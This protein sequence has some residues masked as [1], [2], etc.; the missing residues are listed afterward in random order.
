MEEKF[1]VIDKSLG[2]V[3]QIEEFVPVWKMPM[4]FTKDF[5]KIAD[6]IESND[7]KVIEMP[8]GYYKDMD[9]ELEVNRSKLSMFLSMFTKK[10]HLFV[11]M[12]SSQALPGSGELTAQNK[13]MQKFVKAVHNGPYQTSNKT[14]RALL[15]W[16]RSQGLSLKNEAYE[17]Y[18]NDPRKVKKDEIETIIL[19]PLDNLSA[20]SQKCIKPASLKM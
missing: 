12:I 4:T 8:Y 5:K 16:S 2:H 11:G 14:Y 10:W 6:Y 18:A 17:L 19:V 15:D 3:I 20:L 13:G 1:S 9:W 7:A